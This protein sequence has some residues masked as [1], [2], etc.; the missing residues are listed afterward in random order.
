MIDAHDTVRP[1]PKRSRFSMQCAEDR[2]TVVI[3]GT[4]TIGYGA[5]ETEVT[6][7]AN[8]WLLAKKLMLP[9]GSPVPTQSESQG[10]TKRAKQLAK[11]AIQLSG[12]A[13]I[14]IVLA[15]AAPS[16]ARSPLGTIQGT[17]AAV[18]HLAQGVGAFTYWLNGPDGEVITLLRLPQTAAAQAGAK[19]RGFVLRFSVVLAP[20]QTQTIS[21]PGIDWGNP[22]TIYIRRLG[23][24][25]E[26][27]SSNADESQA[28]SEPR[29]LG[30][31]GDA[32]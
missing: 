1:L 15:A 3:E 19:D 7:T 30:E 4:T 13:V 12:T 23:Q 29:G 8:V 20:G 21:V 10:V 25:I 27:T 22:P 6:E 24:K 14:A 26:V 28:I 2:H 18:T 11:A 31:V 32:R 16:K 5:A 9:A 17:N